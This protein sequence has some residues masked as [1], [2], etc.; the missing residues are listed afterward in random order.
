MQEKPTNLH[1]LKVLLGVSGGVA[2]YKAVELASKLT[3]QGADL[4][5]VMTESA[6]RLVRAKSFEAV[7]ASA[8]YT[9]LWES[10]EQSEISHITLRDWADIIVLAPATANIMGKTAN[11]ICDD[12][13]SSLLCACWSKPILIAPSMNENMWK[14]PAVQKNAQQLKKMGCEL[15]GPKTGRLACGEKGTGRMSEPDEI[16]KEIR[17]LAT[18][19]K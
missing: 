1:G 8:V 17:K 10:S 14:N 7:T 2:A 15:T 5:T 13:L 11:G 19:K 9:S 3:S 4:K 6:S 12:L 16:I 18:G